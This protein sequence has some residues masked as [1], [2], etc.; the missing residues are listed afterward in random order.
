MHEITVARTGWWSLVRR[1]RSHW[2]LIWGWRGNSLPA[3]FGGPW[4]HHSV[5]RLRWDDSLLRLGGSHPGCLCLLLRILLELHLARRLG[6][7]AAQLARR[8]E[9]YFGGP[10][11]FPAAVDR[12]KPA[13]RL[14]APRDE[15]SQILVLRH[16]KE[17]RR[18]F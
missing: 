14:S 17:R 8:P 4:R 5:V 12:P 15:T 7:R 10:C 9:L 18:P 16:L 2:L 13:G 1:W 11:R 6:D 3:Y